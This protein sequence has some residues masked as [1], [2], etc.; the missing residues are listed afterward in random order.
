MW[1]R[2][3]ELKVCTTITAKAIFQGFLIIPRLIW[4]GTSVFST[5]SYA[6]HQRIRRLPFEI[7]KL[8]TQLF[9]LMT[10]SGTMTASRS[11]FAAGCRETPFANGCYASRNPSGPGWCR[12][13]RWWRFASCAEDDAATSKEGN[14]A[15]KRVCCKKRVINLTSFQRSCT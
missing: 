2:E 13:S 15:R 9:H 5:S 1:E 11:C 14:L 12:L 6:I 8:P 7:A 4:K 10:R 3:H